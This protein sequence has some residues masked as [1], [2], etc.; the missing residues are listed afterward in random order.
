MRTVTRKRL[1]RFRGGEPQGGVKTRSSLNSPIVLRSRRRRSK[2][3]ESR[4][5]RG[6]R[7][8]KK[9]QGF[10]RVSGKKEDFC[11]RSPFQISQQEDKAG[12]SGERQKPGK[13]NRKSRIGKKSLKSGKKKKVSFLKTKQHV[14]KAWRGA[15]GRK[16][17]P[18]GSQKPTR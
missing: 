2:G 6:P 15:A 14:D 3:V 17:G 9:P 11:Q 1:R 13:K 12:W 5:I 10:R 8:V 4:I 16:P 18:E 7:E